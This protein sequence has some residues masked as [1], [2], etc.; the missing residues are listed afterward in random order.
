M[1]GHNW[2][3]FE[4]FLLEIMKT[5]ALVRNNMQDMIFAQ[6]NMDVWCE[7]AVLFRKIVSIQ[8]L[9][10]FWLIWMNVEIL[11][12][13]S[14]CLERLVPIWTTRT[15][16]FLLSKSHSESNVIACD[17]SYLNFVE[18]LQYLS[19]DLVTPELMRYASDLI[20]LFDDNVSEPIVASELHPTFVD[21]NKM[22]R[23][24]R[25]IG[26]GREAKRLPCREI[27]DRVRGYHDGLE[28]QACGSETN[29]KAN[30][31]AAG[32]EERDGGEGRVLWGVARSRHSVS[33]SPPSPHRGT[34]AFLGG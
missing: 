28:Q 10:T 27:R 8:P 7:M 31:D 22:V 19:E 18:C 24:N 3:M 14:I 9:W 34:S 21:L 13:W 30:C 12:S 32:R 20:R 23:V 2:K 1:D 16:Q 17:C 6:A 29:R 15:P 5:S 33:S 11:A 4:S 26:R 25:V